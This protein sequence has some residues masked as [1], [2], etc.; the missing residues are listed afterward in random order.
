MGWGLSHSPR[1]WRREWA[2]G[3][4]CSP[5]LEQVSGSFPLSLSL[6]L[7]SLHSSFTLLTFRRGHNLGL[8]LRRLVGTA[9][10]TTLPHCSTL[11]WGGVQHLVAVHH[12]LRYVP[13]SLFLHSST[14]I[15]SFPLV[16][17]LFFHSSSSLYISHLHPDSPSNLSPLVLTYILTLRFTLNSHFSLCFTYF[18]LFSFSLF[19][20]FLSPSLSHFRFN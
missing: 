14:S 2:E 16:W 18:L 9:V 6:S 13:L 7:F 8:V 20:T 5:P 12:S 17:F 15:S 11:A 10:L 4:V 1:G 19:I 3:T